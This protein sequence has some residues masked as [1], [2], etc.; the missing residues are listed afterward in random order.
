[1][2]NCPSSAIAFVT[3]DLRT[4]NDAAN[5]TGL[6]ISD[7]ISCPKESREAKNPG[8]ITYI[9]SD[10]KAYRA[11]INSQNRI[12]KTV[13]FSFGTNANIADYSDMIVHDDFVIVRLQSSDTFQ[14]FIRPKPEGSFNVRLP[15][16]PP[17]TISPST[18]GSMT[19]KAELGFTDA[20]K[21]KL[22]LYITPN[23]AL[24]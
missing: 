4:S 7:T 14:A 10:N 3:A 22:Y 8:T 11:F 23:W 24:Q 18:D 15:Q 21:L 16:T 5:A 9:G 1:V 2:L 13:I 19:H 6:S 17:L 20:D 12:D